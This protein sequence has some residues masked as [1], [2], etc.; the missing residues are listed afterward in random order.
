MD[1]PPGLSIVKSFSGG[2]GLGWGGGVGGIIY[3]RGDYTLWLKHRHSQQSIMT[4]FFKCNQWAMW[5]K[6][7]C[8]RFVLFGELAI[9]RAGE[10]GG[11]YTRM[12]YAWGA[13]EGSMRGWDYLWN[14]KRNNNNNNNNIIPCFKLTWLWSTWSWTLLIKKFIPL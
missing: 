4:C 12:S 7:N 1:S 2:W 6:Q 5:K 11:G 10:M 9:Y 8:C 3:R 13:M 14:L